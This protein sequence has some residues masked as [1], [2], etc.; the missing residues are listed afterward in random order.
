MSFSYPWL[1]LPQQHFRMLLLE[2]LPVR[3]RN[4]RDDILREHLPVRPRNY[5]DDMLLLD[6]L[7]RPRNYRD[8]MLLLIL[9]GQFETRRYLVLLQALNSF[10]ASEHFLLASLQKRE[11]QSS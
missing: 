3:P 1:S 4:Y 2:R 5:R 9:L 7:P 6:R 8:D 11:I 10:S